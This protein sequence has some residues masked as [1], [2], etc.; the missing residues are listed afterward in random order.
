MRVRIFLLCLVFAITACTTP[1]SERVDFPV[2]E[3]PDRPLEV[4]Q[5]LNGHYGEQDFQFQVRISLGVT[6]MQMV[7]IDALGRR[8]FSLH[9][10]KDGVVAER[11]DGVSENIKA[12]DILKVIIATYW[13]ADHPLQQ[14]VSDRTD[15]LKISYQGSRDNAWNETVEI[16]DPKTDY[17]MSILSYELTQ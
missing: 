13:P 9:W 8:A 12:E 4:V 6:K 15:D 16:R 1:S 11:A 14:F 10:D 3:L 17:E 5:V 2:W 7:G